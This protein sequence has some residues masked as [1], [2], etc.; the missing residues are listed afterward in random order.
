MDTVTD[1]VQKKFSNTVS[2]FIIVGASKRGWPHGPQALST[3]ALLQLCPSS[4]VRFDWFVC[5]W[6]WNSLFERICFDDHYWCLSSS[7]FLLYIQIDCA[8]G[9]LPIH[10]ACR[11]AELYPE[12]ASLLSSS[13]RM[14]LCPQ[15]LLCH[16]LHQGNRPAFNCTGWAETVTC[17]AY[18]CNKWLYLLIASMIG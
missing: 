5:P 18:C 4:W 13:G 12:R 10:C 9:H 16:E 2:T 3:S 17:L 11:C 14:E 6:Y 1:Y 7:G 8:L 15:G